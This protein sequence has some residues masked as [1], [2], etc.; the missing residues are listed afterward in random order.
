VDAAGEEFTAGG[1][2]GTEALGNLA[3][4]AGEAIC[5]RGAA[6]NVAAGM[7][8]DNGLDLAMSSFMSHFHVGR[9]GRLPFVGSEIGWSFA[10]A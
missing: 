2:G 8:G 1:R 4:G 5:T 6:E 9:D 7:C 10:V 3:Q